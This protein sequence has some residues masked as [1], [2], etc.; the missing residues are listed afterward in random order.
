MLPLPRPQY[1][2]APLTSCPLTCHAGFDPF[3]YSFP[4]AVAQSGPRPFLI[5]FCGD[6]K[7]YFYLLLLFCCDAGL[8]PSFWR[9][10]AAMTGIASPISPRGYALQILALRM[11]FRCCYAGWTTSAMMSWAVFFAILCCACPL[12]LPL[13]S[14][15]AGV[16]ASSVYDFYFLLQ[17]SARLCSL[18]VL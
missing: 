7:K 4:S 14:A 1:P 17:R 3:Q 15:A 12:C 16:S 2:R 10:T 9:F 8:D 18:F 5:L 11:S 6:A 13:S